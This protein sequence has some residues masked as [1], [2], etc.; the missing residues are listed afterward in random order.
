MVMN[1]NRGHN[2][3]I[4]ELPHL[5]FGQNKVQNCKLQLYNTH[6]CYVCR[7]KQEG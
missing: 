5:R 2:R 7:V 1:R 4:K 3:E 6:I